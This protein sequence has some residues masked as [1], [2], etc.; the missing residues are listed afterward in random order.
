VVTVQPAWGDATTAIVLDGARIAPGAPVVLVEPP[1][2]RAW[3]GSSASS[4]TATPPSAIEVEDVPAAR[5]RYAQVTVTLDIEHTYKLDLEIELY[6]PRG[7]PLQV[8]DGSGGG[9][10][11]VRGAFPLDLRR[12]RRSPAPG[13]WW[14]PTR[15]RL[16]TGT[17]D[18]VEAGASATASA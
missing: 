2:R 10:N 16:D 18:R 9:D 5:E 13:A 7:E 8:F 6:P 4:A 14:S 3:P 17:L 12:A 1:S 15:A 11:D